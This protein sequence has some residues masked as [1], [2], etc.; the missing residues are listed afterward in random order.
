VLP[1][2]V[3]RELIEN[4][5]IIG[6][7]SPGCAAAAAELYRSFVK[8][9]LLL[10]GARTAELAKIAENAFRDVNIAFA[11]ELSLIC[12][13]FGMD[14]WEVIGLANRHPRVN[15]L[16]PGPGVGGHCLAVD[17]WFIIAAAGDAATMMRTAREVNDGKPATVVAKIKTAASRF[18]RPVIACLGLSYKANIDDLRES[19]AL[20]IAENLARQ[21]IGEL[22]VVEPNLTVLPGSLA[23]L[24]GVSFANFETA[25]EEA[26]ILALLVPHREFTQIDRALL[27][28]KIV[29]DTCGLWRSR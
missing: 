11:N 22:M 18:Q 29:I 17:P 28:N 21:R 10:T 4:D 19:P 16:R 15:I 5:R 27:A 13:Q 8:G 12:D 3:L 24:S 9:E 14:V 2:S 7:V 1:G 23:D 6:G 20:Q 26:D 25:L